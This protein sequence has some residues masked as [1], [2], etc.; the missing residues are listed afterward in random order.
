VE[1]VD[2]LVAGDFNRGRGKGA[3]H[4]RFTLNTWLALNVPG[5]LQLFG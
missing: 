3:H 1:V 5:S 2:Q 4:S